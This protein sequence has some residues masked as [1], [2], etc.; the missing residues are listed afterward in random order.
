MG[1][2]NEVFVEKNQISAKLQP[3]PFFF[4]RAIFSEKFLMK[5][6]VNLIYGD[7]LIVK[8]S[9]NAR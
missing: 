5:K 3:V 1:W 9:I 4:K 6:D 8:C 7:T 2:K